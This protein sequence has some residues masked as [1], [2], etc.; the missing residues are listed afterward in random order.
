VHDYYVFRVKAPERSR[1]R[2]DLYELLDTIPGDEAFKPLEESACPA[3]R[4]GGAR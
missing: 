3:L 4:R 2:G 1:G